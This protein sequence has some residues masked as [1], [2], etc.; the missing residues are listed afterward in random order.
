[1]THPALASILEGFA[2]TAT[3]F[4]V[5]IYG[6]VVVPRGGVLW[7]GNVVELCAGVGISES[8]A[9]TAVSRLVAAGRLVGTRQGRRS[10]YRLAD[11]SREEFAEAAKRLYGPPP[12][13]QDWFILHAPEL[14]DD[15]ARRAGYGAMGAG[16]FLLPGW[17]RPLP[18][19]LLR[20]APLARIDGLAARLWDLDG[21]AGEYQAML[22]MFG[23]AARLL[24]EGGAI[25]GLDALVLRL[26]LVH[27]FRRILLRDP[28]LPAAALPA[29]WPGLRARS[30]FADLYPRLSQTADS[31]I[32]AQL[33]GEAG[34]LAA[35]TVETQRRLTSLTAGDRTE[36]V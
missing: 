12:Q 2:P 5:T 4:I 8:L 22:D 1:M 11:P 30:L 26:A 9:R 3:T 13:S 34:V 10:F 6:D 24:G 25:G 35:G 23:P 32:G 14:S 18:G 7:M 28:E 20:A 21:L 15:E 33:E 16:T 36:L 17:M 19:M 29:A 27:V 31:F